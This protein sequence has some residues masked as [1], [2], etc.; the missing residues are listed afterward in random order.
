MKKIFTEPEMKKIEL[1]L[2]E[3]I[4]A[5]SFEQVVSTFLDS[6]N[7]VIIDT[8][9]PYGNTA[10]KE[11]VASCIFVFTPR[12]AGTVAIPLSEMRE[13]IR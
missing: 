6:V 4:A 9:I 13:F 12:I 10:T 3:N 8:N 2:K 1:N 7:C 11:E 5:S